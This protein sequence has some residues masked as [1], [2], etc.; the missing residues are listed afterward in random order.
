MKDVVK[1][2]QIQMRQKPASEFFIASV[3]TTQYKMDTDIVLIQ[4]M[5]KL[6]A[7]DDMLLKC[8]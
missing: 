2:S 1:L 3:N 5:P 4:W 8:L 6:V 7:T